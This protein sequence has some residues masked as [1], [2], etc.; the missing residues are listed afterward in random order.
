MTKIKSKELQG[1]SL[2]FKACVKKTLPFFFGER[3]ALFVEFD[4]NLDTI[5]NDRTK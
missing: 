5:F 1:I 3:G 2:D 4:S